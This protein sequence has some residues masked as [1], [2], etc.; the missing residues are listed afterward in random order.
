MRVVD[1]QPAYH[2]LRVTPGALGHSRRTGAW[3]DLVQGQEALAGA[4]LAGAERQLPQIG[5]RLLPALVVNT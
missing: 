3:A 4:S 5:W 2:G 1:V